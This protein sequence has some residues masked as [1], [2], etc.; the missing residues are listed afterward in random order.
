MSDPLLDKIKDLERVV[1]VVCTDIEPRY[2]FLSEDEA[3][4]FVKDFEDE[5]PL[6]TL[7]YYVKEVKVR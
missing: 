1:Y 4:Q 6:N 2:V 3:F 7:I 5:D